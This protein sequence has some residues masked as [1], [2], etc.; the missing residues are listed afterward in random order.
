MKNHKI[1]I[2]FIFML[3]SSSVLGILV[4]LQFQ[5]IETII[6][7]SGPIVAKEVIQSDEPYSIAYTTTGPS[8]L[9]FE[10]DC[11]DGK[12]SLMYYCGIDLKYDG[13]SGIINLKIPAGLMQE[14]DPVR[15]IFT[16]YFFFPS[17]LP[18]QRISNDD[19]YTV[20]RI[21]VP[22][23]FD[24]IRMRGSSLPDP[25]PLIVTSFV[26]ADCIFF[27]LLIMLVSIEEIIKKINKS[28]VKLGN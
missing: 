22:A 9:A 15:E 5:P 2:K 3:L 4:A 6:E 8:I 10:K 27:G 16:S 26:A 12:G 23:K 14:I 18:F 25:I 17:Q 28:K 21:E 1:A 19:S 7:Q 13:R 20:F 11:D 24:E